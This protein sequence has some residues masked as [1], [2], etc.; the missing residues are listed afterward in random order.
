[1]QIAPL[2]KSHELIAAIEALNTLSIE[3]TLNLIERVDLSDTLLIIKLS[4]DT[5]AQTLNINTAHFD[6]EYL[7]LRR[8]SHSAGAVMAPRWCGQTIKASPITP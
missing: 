1:M 6:H 4:H 7:A 8:P 3:Q 5:L 2:I